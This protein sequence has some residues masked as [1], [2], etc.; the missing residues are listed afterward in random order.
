MTTFRALTR[1]SLGLLIGSLC[2]LAGCQSTS[3]RVGQYAIPAEK[4]FA[5]DAYQASAKAGASAPDA[6]T[7]EPITEQVIKGATLSYQLQPGDVVDVKFYYNPDLNEQLVV[8]PDGKV[9]L[10]IIG[11]VDT[12]GLSPA[13]LAKQLTRR[14]ADTLRK[15]EATVILR[16]YALPRIYVAGEVINPSAQ[17]IDSG[18]LTALQAIIQS[19]GFRKSAERQNV[20]ILRQSGTLQPVFIKLDL[21]AQLEQT[22]VTDL[23]LK[24]YDIVFVPQK[25]IAEVAEFFDEYVSKIIPLYRNMGLSFNYDLHRERVVD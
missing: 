10:Q 9:A 2:L 3:Q 15:P 14:Y 4:I 11:E 20:I 17:A 24:P 6:R 5:Q 7:S 1:P 8:G 25:R 23:P 13:Q 19:G 21:Q 18:R 22:A 16:K 12:S